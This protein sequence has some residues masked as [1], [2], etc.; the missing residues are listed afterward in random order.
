MKSH[1]FF[2]IVLSLFTYQ[3]ISAQKG[4]DSIPEAKVFRSIQTIKMGSKTLNF[5]NFPGVSP[6]DPTGGLRTPPSPQ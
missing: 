2:I 5:E 6:L 4:Q 1:H 3:F